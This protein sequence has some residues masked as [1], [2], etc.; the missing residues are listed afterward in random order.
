M[1]IVQK[2]TEKTISPPTMLSNAA[3][4]Y[5]HFS[6]VSGGVQTLIQPFNKG[7]RFITAAPVRK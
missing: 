3:N 6:G 1:T 2:F 5:V 7:Q 4:F